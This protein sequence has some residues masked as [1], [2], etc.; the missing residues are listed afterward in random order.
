MT[1]SPWR[2]LTAAPHRVMFLGGTLQFV[3]A[4]LLWGAELGARHGLPWPPLPLTVAPSVLHATLMLYGLFPFFIFGFLMTTFP[5]WMRGKEI[6]R[7][8]YVSAFLALVGGNALLYLGAF[9]D[10]GVAAAGALGVLIGWGIVW[11]ALLEVYRQ[12]E[13]DDKYYERWLLAA[14]ACGALGLA[15]FVGGVVGSDWRWLRLSEGIGL[16]LFLLPVLIVVSHRMI[17]FFSAC[18]LPG[19][20]EQRPRWTLPLMALCLGG[21]LVTEQAGVPQWSLLFD[22]PLGLAALHHSRLWGLRQAQAVGLL[23]VLHLAFLWLGIG[24]LLYG[25]NDLARLLGHGDTLGRGPLHALTIGFVGSMVVAMVTR[26]SRGHSGRELRMDRL[27][28][29]AFLALQ[30]AA[31]LRIAGEL[32][33]LTAANP[34][35]ALAWLL[36][37][38]PWAL[39]Y[40]LIY[41]RPR[42]DGQPG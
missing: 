6:G 4:L 34:L 29:G 8:R 28:W 2:T 41:L 26:V 21:H 23:W 25:L 35:A 24:L 18:A 30:A 14:L 3:L 22:L 36:L 40:A 12:T 20:R 33:G 16:W 5:R 32:P 19:Y 7:G 11:L 39:R 42:I 13:A 17:P 31:L 38:G 10:R 27:A 9:A 37:G 1:P 15:L